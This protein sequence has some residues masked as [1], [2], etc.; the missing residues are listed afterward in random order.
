MISYILL[1]L[2][3]VA[4]FGILTTVKTGFNEIIKGLEAIDER[5][6]KHSP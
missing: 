2:I 3:A 1:A 5:L 6:S 4:S